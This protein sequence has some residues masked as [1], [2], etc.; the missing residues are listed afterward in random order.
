MIPQLT[1]D[2]CLFTP[3]LKGA[4]QHHRKTTPAVMDTPELKTTYLTTLTS[5][6][7]FHI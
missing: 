3:N 7:L 2:H 6:V 4:V 5:N 1:A